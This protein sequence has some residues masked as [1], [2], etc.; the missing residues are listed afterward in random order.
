VHDDIQG[1]SFW[2]TYMDGRAII[3]DS[4][5]DFISGLPEE[6]NVAKYKKANE[7]GDTSRKIVWA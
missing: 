5:K 6:E 2:P 4:Y 3:G 1:T 7:L